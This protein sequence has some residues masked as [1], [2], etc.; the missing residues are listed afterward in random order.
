MHD[1]LHVGDVDAAGGD[2]GGDHDAHGPGGEGP[3][4]ALA[5]VLAH[6]AL[7]LDGGDA[8]LGEAARQPAGQ[9]LGAREQDAPAGPGGQAPHDVVLGGLVRHRPHAVVHGGHGGRRGVD[10]VVERVVEELLDEPVHAV[11]QGGGEEHALAAG[12]GGA[13]NAA[14][15]GQE[16]EVGHVVGLVQ[17]GDGHLVEVDQALPHEVEQ[18]PGAGDDDVDAGGQ[19]LLL[20]LLG[21]AAEDGGHAQRDGVGQGPD[22]LGDLAGELAGGGQDQADGVTGAGHVLLGQALDQGQGEG[23]GLAGPG[24]PAAQHVAPGEGVGQG[25]TLDGEGGGEAAGAEV[26]DEVGIHAQG[27]EGRR[28]GRGRGGGR[29]GGG[30]RPAGG[31]V[32]GRPG[33]AAGRSRSPAGGARAAGESGRRGAVGLA[34]GGH[35]KSC[36]SG[37]SRAPSAVPQAGA[38][39]RG[40]AGVRGSTAQR[41][42]ADAR[43]GAGAPAGP[44]RVAGPGHSIPDPP[45]S[46]RDRRLARR[47]GPCE[48]GQAV[49]LV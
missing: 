21:H 4:G 34:G 14:H 45:S 3:H 15:G 38:T 25:R 22:G 26:G 43:T 31:G 42:R 35:G 41:R 32:Q 13:Q 23:E 11:V 18:A 12:R 40:G 16:A 9:V 33:G 48:A 49:R 5:G 6:I 7:Q 29:R 44:R 24:A 2:V 37:P 8:V 10:R 30:V 39:V 47:G 1:Q 17:D 28:R 19:G 20:G 36:R 27:G 46:R